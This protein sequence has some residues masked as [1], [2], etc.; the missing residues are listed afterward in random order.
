MQRLYGIITLEV[1][2]MKCPICG[3]KMKEEFMCP[4]CKIT[5]DQVKNASN[6]EAKER[7]KKK[8]TKEVYNST[9]L[10]KDVNNTRLLLLTL[11]GGFLGIHQSY[12]GKWK[13]G[14][15]YCFGFMI[16]LIFFVLSTYIFVENK[17]LQYMSQVG[18]VFAALV[19]FLWIADFF[20]VCFK[21][22]SIPVVLEEGN[23]KKEKVK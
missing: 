5:G 20:K 13:T 9:Y 12:V 11:F 3:C 22:F 15:F 19:I 21:S 8:D 16:P 1:N 7:I 23:V 4:Y 10:P 14:L 6:K 18:Y 2:Y 17:I